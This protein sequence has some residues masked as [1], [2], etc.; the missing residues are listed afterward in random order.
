MAR[1]SVGLKEALH[2]YLERLKIIASAS[3][4]PRGAL[5]P[6]RPRPGPPARGRILLTGDAF[7]L[8]EPI[9]AEGISNGLLSGILAARAI[10]DGGMDP[11]RVAAIYN[12]DLK[13]YVLRELESAR[14]HSQVLYGYRY[15]RN[16][17][18][19]VKGEV[20][21]EKLVDIMM[22]EGRFADIGSPLRLLLR[23]NGWRRQARPLDA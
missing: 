4:K 8:A 13:M 21:C 19:R 23:A 16:L 7:G 3:L 11:S 20:F 17:L 15:L 5:I 9:C 2:A 12:R 22:G 6:V 14:S 18:F 10:I 1:E